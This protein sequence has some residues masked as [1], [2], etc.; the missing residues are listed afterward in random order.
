MAHLKPETWNLKLEMITIRE[1]N[2]AD[3]EQIWKII[4]PI[5]R[6]GDTYVFAPDSSRDNMLDYWCGEDKNTYVAISD[7][8]ILG[9]FFIK[10]NQPDLGSH[11]CNAGYMV[12]QE[13]QGK[14]IGRQ[15]A[16]FSL[17]EA[18]RLGFKA[19]QFNFVVKS[20]AGAIRLWQKLG[21]EIIGEIPEAFQHSEKG[22]TNALIMYRKL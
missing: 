7:E 6:K 17:K 18:K 21:F 16:E 11:I 5:I 13:A 8:K 10:E 20:N 3:K 9:T 22:L 2:E 14:G 12:A 1:Y 19:M 4:K 15:M